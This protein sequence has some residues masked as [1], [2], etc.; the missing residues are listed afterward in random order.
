MPV[1][2]IYPIRNDTDS[3]KPQHVHVQWGRLNA[4]VNLGTVH[5]NPKGTET[6][7]YFVD[8]RDRGEVN[9][10]IRTLRKARDQAFGAD[11]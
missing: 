3:A 6:L 10:L 1:E 2:R 4:S 5:D 9:R 8:L 11:A 7:A